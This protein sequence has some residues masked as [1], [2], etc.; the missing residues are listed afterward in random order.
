[1]MGIVGDVVDISCVFLNINI[2]VVGGVVV[3]LILI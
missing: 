2:V 3:V 1:M